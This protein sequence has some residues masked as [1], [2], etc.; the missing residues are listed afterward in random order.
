MSRTKCSN[1]CESNA[2]LCLVRAQTQEEDGW[3]LEVEVDRS[4]LAPK[5]RPIN[6]C[7]NQDGFF[8]PIPQNI[9]WEGGTGYMCLRHELKG[10]EDVIVSTAE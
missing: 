2:I 4:S 9:L 6:A 10:C 8:C 5:T 7:D 1:L 3:K